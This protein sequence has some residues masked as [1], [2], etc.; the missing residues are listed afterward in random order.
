VRSVSYQEHVVLDCQAA[1]SHSRSFVQRLF[2]FPPL[3]A[4]AT[5]FFCPT[6]WIIESLSIGVERPETVITSTLRLSVESGLSVH[7]V[8]I[9]HHLV[10]AGGIKMG[11][12]LGGLDACMTQ[13]LL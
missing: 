6:L 12:D 2:I 10:K 9:A 13:Q 11:V 4:I 7:R 3:T 5:A 8:E 1:A